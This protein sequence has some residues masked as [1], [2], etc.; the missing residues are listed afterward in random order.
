MSEHE[1]RVFA[2]NIETTSPYW[3]V[4]DVFQTA[5]PGQ[6]AILLRHRYDTPTQ[7]YVWAHTEDTIR[8]IADEGKA[9]ME[10]YEFMTAGM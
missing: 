2:G 9:S 8:E 4:E 6:W 1:A 3:Y 10:D 7:L 5:N